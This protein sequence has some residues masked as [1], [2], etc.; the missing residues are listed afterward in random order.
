MMTKIQKKLAMLNALN[1]CMNEIEW[2]VQNAKDNA[3][4][5]EER[6][7]RDDY[8]WEEYDDKELEERKYIVECYETIIATLEKLV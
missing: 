7:Q 4:S 5:Y 8:T 6:K 3:E 2:R 1:A